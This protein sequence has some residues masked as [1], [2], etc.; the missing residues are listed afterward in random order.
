MIRTQVSLDR[1]LYE[2]AKQAAR[3][4]G[5]SFA[6]LCR[7]SLAETLSRKPRQKPWME[8]VGM[9]GGRPEDSTTVDEVLYGRTS[10]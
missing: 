6:E 1:E 10:P 3:R 5:I 2:R 4:E 7:R 9:L 8:Y